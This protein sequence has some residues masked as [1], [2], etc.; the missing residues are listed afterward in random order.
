MRC[1]YKATWGKFEWFLSPCCLAKEQQLLNFY[2]FF[3]CSTD[4]YFPRKN[5]N[6]HAFQSLIFYSQFIGWVTPEISHV[7]ATVQ[8]QRFSTTRERIIKVVSQGCKSFLTFSANMWQR[9]LCSHESKPFLA[10]AVDKYCS[11]HPSSVPYKTFLWLCNKGRIS[12]LHSCGNGPLVLLIKE[13][14]LWLYSV[15]WMNHFDVDFFS[16]SHS[17]LET[18]NIFLYWIFKNIVCVKNSCFSHRMACIWMRIWN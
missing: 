15:I 7:A 2:L 6:D 13:I 1:T 10:V 8:M 17:L 14:K 11:G 16:L 4:V 5:V 3:Y 9:L 18:S 12:Q